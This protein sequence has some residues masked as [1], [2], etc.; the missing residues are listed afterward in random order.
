[1]LDRR[2][3]SPYYTS[4]RVRSAENLGRNIIDLVYNSR[5]GSLIRYARY[6]SLIRRYIDP[7]LSYL[8]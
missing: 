3:R 1:M 8:D 7:L 5:K 4:R 6:Y 2:R